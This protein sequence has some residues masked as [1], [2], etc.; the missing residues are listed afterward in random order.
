MYVC[1]YIFASRI[2]RYTGKYR[3][4]GGR[5]FCLVGQ[6]V[7]W[8]LV[9]WGLRTCFDGKI[10]FLKKK[11]PGLTY[12]ALTEIVKMAI[13]EIVFTKAWLPW[14]RSNKVSW[15]K[16]CQHFSNSHIALHQI[17]T[18]NIYKYKLFS[19]FKFP[20]SSLWG[21]TLGNSKKSCNIR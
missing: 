17:L 8:F 6:I 4:Q 3:N 1:T 7:I 18:Y 16:V 5:I 20:S 14:N 10:D 21:E 2:I 9:I 19:F 12:F 15:K 13:F 11:F